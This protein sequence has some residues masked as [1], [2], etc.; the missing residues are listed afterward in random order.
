MFYVCLSDLFVAHV[1]CGH[2]GIVVMQVFPSVTGF[3]CWFS[4]PCLLATGPRLALSGGKPFCVQKLGLLRV[5][6]KTGSGAGTGAA[7]LG[8]RLRERVPDRVSRLGGVYGFFVR[9]AHSRIYG[10]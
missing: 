3:Y 8:G 9:S 7:P 2:L 4:L 5:I 1:F 6:I 10:K